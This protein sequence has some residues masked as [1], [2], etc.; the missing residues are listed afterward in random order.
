MTHKLPL[1]ILFV[2]AIAVNVSAQATTATIYGTLIDSNGSA[3][4]E[5]K[6]TLENPATGQ[7]ASTTSDT[8]G[9]F[10]F[11]F[12]PVGRYIVRVEAPG[13]QDHSVEAL[14][15]ASGQTLRLPIELLV[16]AV[17]ES[18]TITADAP[19]INRVT[20]EQRVTKDERQTREL[21][22]ATRDWVSLLRL[23]NGTALRLGAT[24]IT[25][26]GLAPFAFLFTVDGTNSSQDQEFSSFG[27]EAGI[28]FVKGVSLD[29]I[30]EVSTAK[31]IFSADISRTLSGN[32]NVI[33]KSGSNELHGS[34]FY[35][36]QL[37]EYNARNPL[38]A[39]R[40]PLTFN[41]YGGSLGGPIIKDKLFF[42]GAYEGYQLRSFQAVSGDVPTLEFR[43]RAVA[44]VPAYG[45]Y[46]GCA[47]RGRQCSIRGSGFATG[48]RQSR[49]HP[50]RLPLFGSK[51]A[52][53]TL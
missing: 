39:T 16:G 18:V 34:L 35:N 44:A 11:S 32:V 48:F 28:Q 20:A 8:R 15:L 9:E 30:H 2:A 45:A 12:V 53:R 43:Q 41:Q 29:A 50:Y 25:M 22:V 14:D 26:N 36:N 33:T 24:N 40:P 31:G 27:V 46:R 4:S 10:V 17:R 23:N 7:T 38:L 1:L 21:P 3:V 19:V 47:T 51:P 42:F 6:V 5:A 49:R 13:F 37:D 52:D